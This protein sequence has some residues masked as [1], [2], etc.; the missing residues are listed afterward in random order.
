MEGNSAWVGR[1]GLRKGG[2]KRSWKTVD[3][4]SGKTYRKGKHSLTGVVEENAGN[5]T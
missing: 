5:E 3:T 4:Q 1:R 2:G